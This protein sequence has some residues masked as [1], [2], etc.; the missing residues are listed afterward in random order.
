MAAFDTAVPTVDISPFTAPEAHS[1]AARR[2]VGE[3]WDAAMTNVGF[4]MITGHGVDPGIVDALRRGAHSF[5]GGP[6]DAKQRYCY[7]PYGNPLGG[8]TSMGVEA[9]A[10]SRDDHGSDGGATQTTALPDLVESFGF[11]PEETTKPKPP[12]M[13]DAGHAYHAALLKVLDALHRVTASALGLEEDFFAPFYA[14][15]A[16]CSLRLAYYPPLSTTQQTSSAVRYGAHTDYTGYT[17]LCQDDNDVGALDAG[18]LQV[19]LKSGRWAAVTPRRNAFVV[20]IGDLY[21]VWTNGRWRS[22]VHRV[23]KPPP[24]SQASIQ[25]RLS[26]PFFTGPHDDARISCLPTCVSDTNPAKYQ[27]VSAGEH[28]RRKLGISNV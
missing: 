6:A 5:F 21:E 14:P 11:K 1:D 9:V 27:P 20:N 18:G 2:A 4:A 28:L 19:V 24:G 3:E 12:S 16:K 22:T 8:F 25:P 17:I 10:R 26:I 7:G 13:D 23:M 15:A